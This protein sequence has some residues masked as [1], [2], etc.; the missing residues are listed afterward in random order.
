MI[1][2]NNRQYEF[3][4]GDTLLD[5]ANDNSLNIPTLCHLKDTAPTG[6]CRMCVVE[7]EGASMLLPSCNTPAREGMEVKTHSDRVVSA[8]KGILELLLSSGDH[9]CILCNSNGNCEL[10]DLAVEYKADSRSL[11]QTGCP[12]HMEDDNALILRD[13]SKCIHCGRCV[14]ACNEIQENG[15]LQFGHENGRPKIFA[16]DNQTLKESDCVFCGECVQACP[17]DALSER[18]SRFVGKVRDEKKVRTTCPYCGVG[19]QLWL[20]VR[21]D[22]IVRVTGVDDG[23]PNKGRTCVTGNRSGAGCDYQPCTPPPDPATHNYHCCYRECSGD[24]QKR[25]AVPE[26]PCGQKQRGRNGFSLP[27]LPA[28]ACYTTVA[29]CL[30]LPLPPHTYDRLRWELCL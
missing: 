14:K 5:I 7:V 4:E 25:A 20:H 21:D 2:I 28:P 10:Q 19:C 1:T 11:P 18:K 30:P 27:F 6:A 16:G 29:T 13:S 12:S 22:R 24:H 23:L 17:T 9:H 15:V 3:R 26:Y 8:R